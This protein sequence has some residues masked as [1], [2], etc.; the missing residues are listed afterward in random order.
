[1]RLVA[2]HFQSF[3]LDGLA[4]APSH[5]IF[6]PRFKVEPVV[7]SRQA[8]DILGYESSLCLGLAGIRGRPHTSLITREA[9]VVVSLGC[10]LG[11]GLL[12]RDLDAFAPDAKIVAVDIDPVRLTRTDLPIDLPIW[13]DVGSILTELVRLLGESERLPDWTGWRARCAQVKAAHPT[14]TPDLEREINHLIEKLDKRLQVF[15]PELV[16]LKGSVEESHTRKTP[17]VSLNRLAVHG[18]C[19]TCVGTQRVQASSYHRTDGGGRAPGFW[20]PIG[21][22]R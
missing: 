1:M 10:G 11:A 16:R 5:P 7:A 22:C 12:G 13:A 3:K 17:T 2:A 19:R 20:A 8:Y 21:G 9:D 15:R 14:V 4:A 6:V 18:D